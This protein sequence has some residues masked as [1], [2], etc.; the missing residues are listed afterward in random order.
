RHPFLRI[1]AQMHTAMIRSI[2]V[3]AD[4][5]L[6]ATGS[7]DKTV[8]LW[9][10]PEG[11][12]LR[13]I[14]VP[15]GD[16]EDGKLYAIAL[17]PN[18]RL[19][20]AG[21]WDAYF[22]AN[23]QNDYIYL[24]DTVSGALLRRLGPQRDVVNDLEFSPDGRWLAAGLGG[25]SGVRVWSSAEGFG[26]PPASD[27]E[28]AEA[29]Y[30]ISFDKN[31]HLAVAGWDGMVRIYEV[32]AGTDEVSLNLVQRA[33]PPAGQQPYGISFSPD[34]KRLAVG[35]SDTSAVSILDPVTL[36]QMPGYNIYADNGDLSSVAWSPDGTIL[37]AGGSYHNEQYERPVVA[38]DQGGRGKM[39]VLG[40]LL[41]STFDLAA[42]PGGEGVAWAAGNASFGVF[43]PEGQTLMMHDVVAV[44][45]RNKLAGSLANSAD[46]TA[47]WFGTSFSNLEA[48][49]FDVSQLTFTPTPEIPQGFISPDTTSLP[50]INWQ[51]S[52]QPLFKGRPLQLRSN[53]LS[54]SL[55]IAPDAKSFVLGAEWSIYRFN[56]R[57]RQMWRIPVPD[58]AWGVNL[59]ADGSIIV[60]A[61]ADGTLRWYRAKDGKELLALFVH[62]PDKRW[63]A[64]TPSGYYA[65]APGAEDLIGWHVNGRGWDDTPQ[66]YPASRFRDQFYRP[67]VVQLVLQTL[68]E[69]KAVKE[70]N[71]RAGR[72]DDRKSVE[73][74][75]PASVEL[76]IEAP[77]IKTGQKE[78]AV[79]YRLTSPTGR[80]VTRVEA[81]IDGR[82]VITRGM[83]VITEDYPLNETLEAHI[84]VPPRD[85]ELSIIA[86]IG[87]QPSVSA[88]IPIKWMGVTADARKGKL[89]A[90]LVGV[91]AYA[92]PS[93]KL[94]YAAKDAADFAQALAAQ[95]GRL[96]ESVN[97]VELLDGNAN[98]S[99]VETALARLKKEVGPDDTA[100]IFLAGHGVTD[101]QY[102]FYYLTADAD[103]DPAMLSATAIDGDNIRKTLSQIAGRVVLFMD[104]CRSGAG[105][106][107]KVDMNRLSNDFAQD[108]GGLVMFA[109][110]QGREDSL[111]SP[112]WQN[113][114]FTEAML[115]ILADSSV[116]GADKQ[117]SVPELEEALTVRVRELTEDRQSPVMTKYGDVPR[118]FIAA[119][120]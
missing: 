108:T 101:K 59:S 19:L 110:S 9:S 78:I 85:S 25:G 82:P 97:I 58:I 7:F 61:L 64:W 45:M 77:E 114:A 56:A 4:G 52:Y 109:S 42:L 113:G 83:E 37:Y 40:N 49:T 2:S 3:S 91:S 87:D 73:D 50:V 8:R 27:T 57:G 84:T 38:W 116:Y 102:D 81:R 26:G 103:A 46:A 95:K 74:L 119:T 13:T 67:D 30:G 23:G 71:K 99:A 31:G 66:F 41:S 6:L 20:A 63:I 76:L 54:R 28:Y 65:A 70:A 5:K 1:E 79:K 120:Q 90:V 72:K 60:G 17:S 98:K 55:A 106:A 68:D 36:K 107:G 100:V 44:D 43:S 22:N 88:T 47:L 80:G 39:K 18:G 104:A 32:V 112:A 92:N 16:G 93:L 21:G 34:G 89:F 94:N 48:Y 75:L 51:S 111:E 10:L 86:Y 33:A 29:A 69:A 15:I 62:V 96:Y 105:I 35:Y 11:R 118:F 24:F 115:A 117:L 53:E 14:R 12:L